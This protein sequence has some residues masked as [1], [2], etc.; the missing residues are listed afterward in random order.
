[1]Y[2]FVTQKL[3]QVFCCECSK[4]WKMTRPVLVGHYL[5]K[6]PISW[7]VVRTWGR[8]QASCFKFSKGER[9]ILEHCPF[10]W[11]LDFLLPSFQCRNSS[12]LSCF[13]IMNASFQCTNIF[14]QIDQYFDWC[15]IQTV[16][17]ISAVISFNYSVS[18]IQ[19]K[20]L[21][22]NWKCK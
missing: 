3:F 10:L 19:P 7:T 18:I 4:T 9:E 12:S 20:R 21:E 1:M 13:G 11:R 5:D 17:L 2:G 22:E 15:R 16:T 8:N 6:N 14:R